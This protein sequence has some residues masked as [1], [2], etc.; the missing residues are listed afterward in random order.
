MYSPVERLW[1]VPMFAGPD[2]T[3]FARLVAQAADA[4]RAGVFSS[5]ELD[6]EGLMDGSAGSRFARIY[7]KALVA[8][9]LAA[10]LGIV[11]GMAS[12]AV[13]SGDNGDGMLS[14]LG[15]NGQVDTVGLQDMIAGDA[16]LGGTAAVFQC[17]TG[18]GAPVPAECQFADMDADG[19][20]DLLDVGTY[21]RLANAMN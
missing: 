16:I 7:E 3:E 8:L 13:R 2:N 17:L 9:P 14:L 18:P 15:T 6:I 1:S 4:E 12:M 19:D 21:Q 20:V 11:I 5:T 10:C